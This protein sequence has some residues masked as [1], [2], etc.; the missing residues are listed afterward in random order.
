MKS[1]KKIIL[2]IL[3]F[4][5]LIIIL[6]IVFFLFIIKKNGITEFDK[7]LEIIDKPIVDLQGTDRIPKT[8]FWIKKNDSGNWFNVDWIH[9]HKNNAIISIYDKYG[10][11][12]V[13]ESF[14]KI[15]P[16]DDQKFIENLKVEIDFYDGENI[17][18]R[19]KCYLL[20]RK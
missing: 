6:F 19:D 5:S 13:K 18:L 20:K 9:N 11:L 1:A 2:Q 7:H 15:C 12:V 14:L 8:A 3:L 17:Q 16:N 4:T 10:E